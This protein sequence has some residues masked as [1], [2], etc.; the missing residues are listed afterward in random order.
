MAGGGLY[1][2]RRHRDKD[3]VGIVRWAFGGYSREVQ[4][5]KEAQK[6]VVGDTREESCSAH[7]SA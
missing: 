2:I 6:I 5:S 4:S 1:C 3:I 7:R